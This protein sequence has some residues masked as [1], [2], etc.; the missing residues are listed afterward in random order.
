MEDNFKKIVDK[1]MLTALVGIL[2]EA[3]TTELK[4]LPFIAQSCAKHGMP[5]KNI[6]AYLQDFAD[7]MSSKSTE[8][9]QAEQDKQ[10]LA[11]LLANSGILT[12]G[13]AQEGDKSDGNG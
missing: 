11:E 6:P 3:D 5:V 1:F 9:K 10:N 8:I 2:D 7:Y 13:F 4:L 12:I